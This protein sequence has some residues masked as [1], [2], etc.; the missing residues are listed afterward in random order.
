M[1]QTDPL[2][3]MLPGAVCK[4]WVRCGRSNCRCSR[5]KLHGP[6]YYRFWREGGR[7]RKQYVK[8]SDVEKVRASCQALRQYRR[9]LKVQLEEW[10]GL[11]NLI[12]EIEKR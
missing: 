4:Q 8:R 7:L 11:V 9:D 2:P 5:E 12:R 3:K 10:R 6:Y 1:N